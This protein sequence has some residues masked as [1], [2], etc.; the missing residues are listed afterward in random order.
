MDGDEPVVMH[1]IPLL[2]ACITREQVLCLS[3][4]ARRLG[5][6]AYVGKMQDRWHRS[7]EGSCFRAAEWGTMHHPVVDIITIIDA[8]HP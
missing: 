7:L 3:H 2:H 5:W 8:D 6:C 1:D 4:A